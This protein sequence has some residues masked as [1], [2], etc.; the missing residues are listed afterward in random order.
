MTTSEAAPVEK[1]FARL[2]A[3][4]GTAPAPEQAP[5]EDLGVMHAPDP[6]GHFMLV[7]LPEVEIVT[8]KG[9]YIPDA[10]SERERVASVIGTVIAMGPDCYRDPDPVVPQSALDAGVPIFM[11]AP[12]PRFPSG[13]WCKVGDTVMF[14]RYGG[15][16]FMIE[17]VEFRMLADDE[18]T[19][20]IPPEAK[21]AVGGL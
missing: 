21:A 19:A 17:G 11:L 18:I 8:A 4:A 3:L 15:K 20:T 12:R 10:T 14:S 2:A 5:E 9:I 6:V 13:A 7:A 1:G 16:R